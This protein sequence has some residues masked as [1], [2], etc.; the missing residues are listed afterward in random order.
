MFVYEINVMTK[1]PREPKGFLLQVVFFL[2]IIF[3]ILRVCNSV[4]INSDYSI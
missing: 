3:K 4:N 2:E 1:I